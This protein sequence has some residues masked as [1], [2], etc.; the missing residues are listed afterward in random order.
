MENEP[1]E[2]ATESARESARQQRRGATGGGLDEW[3]DEV[4]LARFHPAFVTRLIYFY[5]TSGFDDCSNC[6]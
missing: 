6:S 1:E 5:L 3:V 4:E 2:K